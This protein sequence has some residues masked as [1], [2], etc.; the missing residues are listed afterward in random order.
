MGDVGCV[1]ILRFAQDDGKNKQRQLQLQAQL[2]KRNAKAKC[3]SEMQKR[4]AGVVRFAQ[5]DR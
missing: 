4:N 2:Q 5:D 1:G 3:K